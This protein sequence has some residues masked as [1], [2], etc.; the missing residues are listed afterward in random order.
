MNIFKK[1]KESTLPEVLYF[2][3]E[4]AAFD[5][6]CKFFDNTIKEGTV[7]AAVVVHPP[8]IPNTMKS[9]KIEEDGV[10]LAFLKVVG[11]NGGF[12]VTA[13]TAGATGPYLNAGDLVAWQP[14]QYSAELAKIFGDER[15]GWVG[16]IVA[17]LKP[18]FKV[19]NGWAVDKPF[20]GL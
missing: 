5:T 8:G 4:H 12:S 1:K 9:V 15:S 13:Q 14:L 6:A 18:E 20:S 10:Q 19:G 16:L 17:K 3:D 2:K 11:E 7:L